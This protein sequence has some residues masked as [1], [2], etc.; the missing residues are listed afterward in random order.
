L[1]D[2]LPIKTFSPQL[3]NIVGQP[4][5][6]SLISRKLGGELPGFAAPSCR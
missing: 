5:L 1:V 2:R 4:L 3:T 6:S